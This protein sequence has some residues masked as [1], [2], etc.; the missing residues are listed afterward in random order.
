MM[1]NK[2]TIRL[3]EIQDLDEIVQLYKQCAYSMNLNGLFNWSE[4]YPGKNIIE[5]DII[6]H[7]LFIYE[8]VSIKGALTLTESQ[9]ENYKYVK[10]TSDLNKSI[11]VRRLAVH[12]GEQG[13]GI[14]KELV[15]FS[16][17]YAKNKDFSFIR[18][19]VYSLSSIALKLYKHN[20][21]QIKGEFLQE[22]IK[23]VYIA[24]EKVLQ[25]KK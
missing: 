21:Y 1:P 7:E 3:A 17:K 19:D 23:E 24:M 18:L 11:V 13:K 12:P 9:P 2:N 15:H 6:N 14:A 25:V 22:G 16:E 20:G 8:E 10:W 5:R 4:N